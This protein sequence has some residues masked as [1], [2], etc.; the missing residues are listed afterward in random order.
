MNMKNRV[1]KLGIL[2]IVGLIIA[3]AAIVLGAEKFQKTEVY[4]GKIVNDELILCDGEGNEIGRV[5]IIMLGEE[6]PK[7]ETEFDYLLEIAKKDSR[8]QEL[9]EGKEY[10]VVIVTTKID[11]D[12]VLMLLKIEGTYYKITI[13]VSRETVQ[14]VEKL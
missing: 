1:T 14:E 8:V 5:N 6:I 13:D 11:E 4:K 9:I 2:V 7:T 10:D 3:S 12:V